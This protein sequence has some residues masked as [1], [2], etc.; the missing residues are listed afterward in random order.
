MDILMNILGKYKF[1][2]F[3]KRASQGILVN[4]ILFPQ[5]KFL[6]TRTQG[7]LLHD[8]FFWPLACSKRGKGKKK[9][10]RI[11]WQEFTL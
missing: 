7:E 4:V 2:L 1:I 9:M 8:H 5:G 3:C 6:I 10:K 11:S